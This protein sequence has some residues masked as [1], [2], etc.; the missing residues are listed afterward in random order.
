MQVDLSDES[1]SG[2]RSRRRSDDNIKNNYKVIACEAP[3]W[4]HLVQ[5]RENWWIRENISFLIK[6]LL[7]NIHVCL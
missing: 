2:G 3:D 5:D 7:H 6:V 4:M 1:S